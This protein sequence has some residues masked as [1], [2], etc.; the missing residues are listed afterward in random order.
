M[1]GDLGGFEDFLRA[2]PIR[3]GGKVARRAVEDGVHKGRNVGTRTADQARRHGH[4]QGG[5]IFAKWL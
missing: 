3:K 5:T 4:K 1:M 2:K